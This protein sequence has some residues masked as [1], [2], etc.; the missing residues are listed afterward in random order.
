[1]ANPN[2]KLKE[3]VLN[4]Q[5]EKYIKEMLVKLS[6]DC[7]KTMSHIVREMVEARYRMRFNNEPACLDCNACKCPQMHIVQQQQRIPG[8][9]LVER[10]SPQNG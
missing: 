6:E 9:E 7:G 5:M 3:V 4:V 10:E 1:M 8:H 2:Q